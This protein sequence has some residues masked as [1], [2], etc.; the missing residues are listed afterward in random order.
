MALANQSCQQTQA[1]ETGPVASESPVGSSPT[2]FANRVNHGEDCA[3]DRLR[4][5]IPSADHLLQIRVIR[6]QFEP[7]RAP[8]CSA[9]AV[10]HSSQNTQPQA[11]FPVASNSSAGS[12]PAASIPGVC[13]VS[14]DD[15]DPC[16]AGAFSCAAKQTC[17]LRHPAIG[18]ECP[19]F[20]GPTH[21]RPP[22]CRSLARYRAARPR[23]VP[24]ETP[25]RPAQRGFA[26]GF[27]QVSKPILP[28]SP[29]FPSCY[30]G[31][32]EPACHARPCIR[33]AIPQPR[34]KSESCR[35]RRRPCFPPAGQSDRKSWP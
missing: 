8:E 17:P 29:D 6:R 16:K 4:H 3:A 20:R 7:L 26:V 34:C 5:S 28:D 13:R 14:H 23:S 30:A 35:F 32:S 2:A 22:V 10:R 18:R 15:A 27:H 1:Q 33:I 11:S 12:I 25:D 9:S 21:R 31:S 24:P 19:A